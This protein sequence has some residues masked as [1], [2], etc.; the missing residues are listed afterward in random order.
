MNGRLYALLADGVLVLHASYVLFV[1]GGQLL[2]VVGWIRHWAWTRNGWFR[3]LHLGAIGFVVA[4]AWLGV[5]CP[6][7]LLE[8]NLRGLAGSARYD[9]SFIAHWLGRL[10]FYTAPA[11]AFTLLYSLFGLLVVITLVLYP[12]R[13]T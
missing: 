4:E 8:N 6:L 11:W 9:M 13:R 3:W 5:R 12:P 7:T 1:V 10:L 2:I